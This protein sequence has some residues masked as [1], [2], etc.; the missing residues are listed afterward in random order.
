MRDMSGFPFVVTSRILSH[1]E[2]EELSLPVSIGFCTLSVA[3]QS[4]KTTDRTQH[5]RAVAYLPRYNC[6]YLV[7]VETPTE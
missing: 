5:L 2:D 3:E 4:I 6:L 1:A 7:E